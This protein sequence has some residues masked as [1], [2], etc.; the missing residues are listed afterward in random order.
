MNPDVVSLRK[1]YRPIDQSVV[2][3]YSVTR[4]QKLSALSEEGRETIEEHV[5]NKCELAAQLIKKGHYEEVANVTSSD[6]VQAYKLVNNINCRW[7]IIPNKFVEV[8]GTP[9]RA[10]TTDDIV[11][12]EG[13]AHIISA[14]GF[15]NIET[16]EYFE[17]KK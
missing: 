8:V 3:F 11:K 7:Y 6:H 2:D 10:T 5:R 1:P 13:V 17:V 15:L 16:F 12:I 4:E 9:S 14:L